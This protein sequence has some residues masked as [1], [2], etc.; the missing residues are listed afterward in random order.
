[1]STSASST[2][3]APGTIDL[4][5]AVVV[6]SSKLAG[7]SV[8]AIEMLIDEVNKRTLIQWPQAEAW[9]GDG[10]PVVAVGLA[11]ELDGFAGAY[12]GELATEANFNTP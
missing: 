1:M 8:K 12:A 11:T 2:S 3:T 9:P 4:S 10:T 6:S 7:P 5:A